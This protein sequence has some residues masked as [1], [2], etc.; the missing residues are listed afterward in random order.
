MSNP[1]PGGGQSPADFTIAP[2]ASP[3]LASVSPN[4]LGTGTAATTLTVT[5]SGFVANSVVQW[6]GSSR[7]T[8]YVSNTQLTVNIPASDLTSALASLPVSVLTPSPGG[9]ASNSVSVAVVSPAVPTISSLSPSQVVLGGPAFTLTVNGTNFVGGAT[10]YWNSIARVTQFVSTNQLSV[11]ILVS[12]IAL[13]SQNSASVTVENPTP[14]AGI[15]AAATMTLENPAP[16]VTS[17]SPNTGVAGAP[18]GVSITGKGFVLGATAQFD[19]QMLPTT[20]NSPTSLSV[21]LDA[22]VGSANLA[23]SNPAPSAGPSNTVTFTGTA[24]GQGVQ[25][26]VA[27]VDSS[28]NT[29]SAP[30]MIDARGRYFS[31]FDAKANLFL[32]DTCLGA[33]SG[34]TPTTGLY[35]NFASLPG[36]APFTYEYFVT[37]WISTDG[38]YVDFL[39]TYVETTGK[40]QSAYIVDTCLGISSGC[41]P[42]AILTRVPDTFGALIAE[43]GRYVS[44]GTGGGTAYLYDTCIGA[45]RGCSQGTVAPVTSDSFTI[46]VPNSDG[47]YLIYKNKSSEI[48]LHDSCLSAAPGCVPTEQTVSDTTLACQAPTISPDA[49]Y[50]AWTCYAGTGPAYLQATC[51]GL[52]SGCSTTPFQFASGAITSSPLAISNGGRFTAFE[53]QLNGLLEVYIYDNCNS[54]LAGCKQQ[55]I[56]ISLNYS[57]AVANADSTLV[58]MSND[59]KYILF[60]SAATNLVTLPAGLSNNVSYIALNPI[61]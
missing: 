49:A 32:R 20:Y 33:P 43:A 36:D 40:S 11:A 12:D 18:I 59:G 14:N 35:G 24:A 15:S 37:N 23:I 47:R 17:V 51:F 22:A 61:Q 29:I 25:L 38:Q 48:I 41:T 1:A 9:G 45:P 3:V 6:N 4:T 42:G 52:S 10:V 39:G 46:P 7:P 55:T 54:G 5:G 56:P 31:F 26:T 28:G 2:P 19:G 16:T 30:G 21:T 44:Y 27:S 8:T 58:G 60:S 53:Q 13:P 34:C 50:L 57:G